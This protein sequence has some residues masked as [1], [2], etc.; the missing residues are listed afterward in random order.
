MSKILSIIIWIFIAVLSVPTVLVL[1][2]WNSLPEDAFY[3]TKIAMESFLLRAVSVIPVLAGQLEMKYSDRRFTEA[4]KMILDKKNSAGLEQFLQQVRSANIRIASVSDPAVKQK[5][6]AELLV[7]L[8]DYDQK[9]TQTKEKLVI[10]DNGILPTTSMQL[11]GNDNKSGTE[12]NYPVNDN[13]N[14]A[15]NSGIQRT[16][17]NSVSETVNT[18]KEQLVYLPPT[19]VSRTYPTITTRP[20]RQSNSTLPTSTVIPTLVPTQIPLKISTPVPEQKAEKIQTEEVVQTINNTQKE[21]SSM[22]TD[23]KKEEKNQEPRTEDLEPRT[24]D[25]ELRTKNQEQITK[26]SDKKENNKEKKD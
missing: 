16:V 13:T 24:K 4:E 25:Q 14:T 21:I 2:S 22:I 3:P 9:L 19:T 12:N 6:K 17:T 10:Q 15:G 18:Q 1:V 7:S 20:V 11:T 26:N 23:L 5:L 8:S